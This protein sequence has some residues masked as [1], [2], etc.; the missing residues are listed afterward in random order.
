MKN[1]LAITVLFLS[2]IASAGIYRHDVSLEKYSALANEPQFNC[3]GQVFTIEDTLS[4]N[5]SC[6]L[7]ADSFVLSARH[8]FGRDK[9][10]DISKYRFGFK[11]KYYTPDK[12][13]EFQHDSLTYDIVLFKLQSPVQEIVPAKVN[14]DTNEYNTI[15]TGVGYG[16]VRN[17]LMINGREYLNYKVAGNNVID[18]IGGDK[19][20]GIATVL[21]ADFDHP[22]TGKLN[23]CG[24]VQALPL[25]YV[26][27]GGDSGGGLFKKKGN[28]YQLIGITKGRS[29]QLS[30]STGSYGS[31]AKWTRLSVFSEWIEIAMH[32]MM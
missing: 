27:N 23:K 9:D 16:S 25:E 31:V 13:K 1:L 30:S 32:D 17:A 10:I 11:G 12:Y 15:A 4:F 6:V 28:T 20:N 3:V 5:A 29:G 7:I 24:S 26:T 19:Y 21:M 8:V 18:S 2:F 14:R 22:E